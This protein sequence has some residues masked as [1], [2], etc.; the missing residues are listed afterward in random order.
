MMNANWKQMIGNR[1]PGAAAALA[2]SPLVLYDLS[3]WGLIR[4]EGEDAEAFL[5]G[6]FTVDVK[7]V[8]GGPA[9]LGA[10]CT[11]KGRILADFLLFQHQDA[12]FLW[13]PREALAV[14][15]QK[16]PMYILMSKV[17]MEDVSERMLAFGVGGA[18]A[19]DALKQALGSVPEEDWGLAAGEDLLAIRLPG[20]NSR[21]LVVAENQPAAAIWNGMPDVAEFADQEAWLLQDI[22]QGIPWVFSGAREAFLPQMVNLPALGGVSFD[23][24]CYTGQEVVARM[25]YLGKVKRR[26][27]RALAETADCP[28]PGDALFSGAA[29]KSGQGAGAIV[30][31]AANESGHCE[32][33]AVIE[34]DS[35]E[36]DDLHL[37]ETS[38][39][40]LQVLEL[41]YAAADEC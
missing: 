13:L 33:L 26:M 17:K 35:L 6:Q 29:V 15:M 4:V 38:G 30:Q 16:L 34:Q 3:S 20:E 37:R 21:F 10:Y 14:I 2:Q 18:N 22:R 11:P 32:I 9:S 23:K 1:T 25:K 19:P 28:Q 24:G 40:K 5:Q 31:A 27:Y 36:A 39:P 41:P 8:N 7:K 12:H